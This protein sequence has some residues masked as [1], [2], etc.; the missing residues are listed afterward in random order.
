[1]ICK[2][3]TLKNLQRSVPTLQQAREAFFE[4]PEIKSKLDQARQQ[5]IQDFIEKKRAEHDPNKAYDAEVQKE[6][7]QQQS[8]GRIMTKEQIQKYVPPEKFDETAVTQ[9]DKDVKTL[10]QNLKQGLTDEEKE[11]AQREL[12]EALGEVGEPQES[13]IQTA[14]DCI[15]KKIA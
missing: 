5:A 1:M 13:A 10:E 12:D 14:V 8:A 9:I 2:G 15:I 4:R 6:I 7:A 3:D 11:A